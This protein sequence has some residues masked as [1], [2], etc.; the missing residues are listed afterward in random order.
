[1]Y[2]KKSL[3]YHKKLNLKK[4]HCKTA[5]SVFKQLLPNFKICTFA[6]NFAD[7]HFMKL[8]I[9]YQ[10]KFQAR[11]IAPSQADTEQMLQAYRRKFKWTN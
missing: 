3:I 4:F 8:N 5:I 10:E 2:F 7:P 9:D 6:V 11:H 1:M